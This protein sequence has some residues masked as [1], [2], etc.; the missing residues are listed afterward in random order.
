MN[1]RKGKET[2]KNFRILLDIEFSSTILM[3]GLI[4]KLCPKK[5]SVMQCY[6]QAGSITTNL[7]I[8]IDFTLPKFS[9]T[10]ICDVEL[11][12]GWLH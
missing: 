10:N 11:S 12:C 2:I 6:T 1:T 8:K 5:S 3:R 7:K 9:A 4:I